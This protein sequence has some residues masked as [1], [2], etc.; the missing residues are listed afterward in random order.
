MRIELG[1]FR[2]AIND[3]DRTIKIRNY[4][5]AYANRGRA[6]LKLGDKEG[7]KQ[8]FLK[9]MRLD[10]DNKLATEGLKAL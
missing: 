6:K 9:T 10:P 8:D 3:L 2:E 1:E 7:A 4:Y 5:G